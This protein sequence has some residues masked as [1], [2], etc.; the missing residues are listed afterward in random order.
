MAGKRENPVND[1]TGTA[2][3]GMRERRPRRRAVWAS[4]IGLA[5]IAGFLATR[6]ASASHPDSRPDAHSHHVAPSG[7]YSEY[8]RVAAIYAQ[9]EQV[10]DVLDGLYCY[11]RCSEHSGHYSLLDC[12]ADDHAARCDVCLSEATLA[13]RMNGEGA[14]LGQIRDAVDSLYG[15]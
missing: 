12:F 10:K 7:R 3:G 4:A 14:S 6:D 9:A 1:R 11:C 8:P 15:H 5:A 2:P 13:H